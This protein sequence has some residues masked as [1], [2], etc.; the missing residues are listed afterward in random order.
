MRD[1]YQV[2]ECMKSIMWSTAHTMLFFAMEMHSCSSES[3]RQF[4]SFRRTFRS[5]RPGKQDFQKQEVAMDE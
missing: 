2:E 5:I 4:H 1:K 3:I